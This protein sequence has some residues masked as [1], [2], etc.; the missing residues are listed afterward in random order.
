MEDTQKKLL[1]LVEQFQKKKIDDHTQRYT[2]NASVTHSISEFG[3][4]TLHTASDFQ[5]WT[6]AYDDAKYG[7]KK[8]VTREESAQNSNN[9]IVKPLYPNLNILNIPTPAS[10]LIKKKKTNEETFEMMAK[11]LK[12]KDNIIFS[13]HFL[14]DLTHQQSEFRNNILFNHDDTRFTLSGETFE[15]DPWLYNNVSKNDINWP[16]FVKNIYYTT[17]HYNNKL[18]QLSIPNQLYLN[19]C[20]SHQNFATLF[21]IGFYPI[22]YLMSKCESNISSD[23]VKNYF[24]NE[25]VIPLLFSVFGETFYRDENKI[26]SKSSEI[27]DLVSTPVGEPYLSNYRYKDFF[28]YIPV[29]HI[30]PL[31]YEFTPIPIPW[32]SDINNVVMS[33]ICFHKNNCHDYECSNHN[34]SIIHDN[35]GNIDMNTLYIPQYNSHL[36]HYDNEP[37]HNFEK[38]KLI[39]VNRLVSS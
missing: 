11:R 14:S 12:N 28:D 38:G 31:F 18:V 26:K 15:F 24:N 5:K 6:Q 1:E 35:R 27:H 3:R 19:Q 30:P 39:D 20:F 23:Y 34:F 9:S 21:K 33:N 22:Y 29:C 2:M 32:P 7:F 8:Q 4:K 16:F 25:N 10:T 17:N 37:I 36:Q 13:T